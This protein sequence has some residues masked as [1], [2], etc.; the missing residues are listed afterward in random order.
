MVVEC[1]KCSTKFKLDTDKIKGAAT[2]VRC[3][4][5]RHIFE[6]KKPGASS[7]SGGAGAPR[8][9]AFMSKLNLG[10]SAKGKNS[11]ESLSSKLG[12]YKRLLAILISLSVLGFGIFAWMKGYMV[13][14]FTSGPQETMAPQDPG[15]L[16]LSLYQV[17]GDFFESDSLDRLF[18]ISGI[19]QN[20]YP[21]PVRF[22]RLEGSLHTDTEQNVRKV[23]AFAGNP[24]SEQEIQALSIQQIEALMNNRSGKER[25][26]EYVNSGD[27]IPFSLVFSDFPENL[28]EYTVKA[29][30]S[31]PVPR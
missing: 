22:I 19:V 26:D 21:N 9:Q 29:V 14:T 30:S 2:K 18:V 12:S 20:D 5:C 13:P 27:S 3:S 17:E 16:R 7:A 10:Q 28:S 15:N 1:P 24:I 6:V 23:T 4:R 31:E 25:S 8:S 11:G